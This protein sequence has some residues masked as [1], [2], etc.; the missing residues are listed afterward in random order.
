M[1]VTVSMNEPL[2]FVVDDDQDTR[3][4]YRVILESVGYRVQDAGHVAAAASGFHAVVP[5]VV[6]TDWRLPDGTGLDVCEALHARGATRQVPVVALSGLAVPSALESRARLRGCVEFLEKPA[7]PDTI[8]AAI[9]QALSIGTARRVRA[10]ASRTKRYAER[11]RRRAIDLRSDAANARASAS[12]LLAL[13]AART[14]HP[15]AL[16]IADDSAHYVAVSGDT[17]SLTGYD[18]SE[19]TDLTVWDLTPLPDA[20]AGQGLWLQFIAA[21]QQEGSYRLRRRDGA[22]VE[23]QYCAIANIAPGLHVSAIAQTAPMP[24]TL[25]AP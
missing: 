10:A 8:L 6:L 16:M 1:P 21:G 15:V 23:A 19:L 22:S 13:V 14:D 3:E 18:P 24:A 4:L 20:G 5:D 11:V 25:G 7:D 9:A 12:A 17:R 2:V